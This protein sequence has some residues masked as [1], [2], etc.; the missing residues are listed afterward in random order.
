MSLESLV[1]SL[2]NDAAVRD[3]FRQAPDQVAEQHGIELN[4]DQRAR[5]TGEN[6]A[7]HDDATLL[8]KVS[9]NPGLAAWL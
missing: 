4:D 8:D 1:S 7:G 2:T 3:Q 9:S 5:L 6:W